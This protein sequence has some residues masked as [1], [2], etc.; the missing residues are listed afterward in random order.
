MSKREQLSNKTHRH[1][2]S[3]FKVDAWVVLSLIRIENEYF[4]LTTNL[5]DY[6]NSSFACMLKWCLYEK[7]QYASD[8]EPEYPEHTIQYYSKTSQDQQKTY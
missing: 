6:A 8:N 5:W 2:T 1:Q 3:S 4:I 7:L